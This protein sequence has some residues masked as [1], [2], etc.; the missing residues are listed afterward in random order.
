VREQLGRYELAWRVNGQT[1]TRDAGGGS[2]RVLLR[3]ADG[4]QMTGMLAM[5]TKTFLALVVDR[6]TW[7]QRDC[8]PGV[9]NRPEGTGIATGATQVISVKFR[10]ADT[11]DAGA[12][13]APILGMG[14][15][16]FGA[17]GLRVQARRTRKVL[18]TILSVIVGLVTLF[19]G[20][21][22]VDQLD[23]LESFQD[24]R[25]FIRT[26]TG[27]NDHQGAGGQPG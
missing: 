7:L 2:A 3:M 1:W 13:G 16:Q 25:K 12:K 17:E 8:N 21:A 5:L 27:I 26:L 19:F 22:L 20:V 6:A 4:E 15:L 18:N 24:A 11:K 23:F 9:N 14:T 10:S